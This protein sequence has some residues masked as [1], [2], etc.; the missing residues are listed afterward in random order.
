AHPPGTPRPFAR[1]AEAHV[2]GRWAATG[3]AARTTAPADRTP[4]WAAPGPGRPT[5]AAARGDRT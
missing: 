5:A 1:P 4:S 3:A 2:P